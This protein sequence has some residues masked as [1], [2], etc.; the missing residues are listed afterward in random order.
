MSWPLCWRADL[1]ATEERLAWTERQL[2]ATEG[3]LAR[4]REQYALALKDAAERVEAA[5]TEQ[6]KLV[7]RIVEMT[8]QPPI[9]EKRPA[10]VAAPP[11]PEPASTIEPPATRLTFADV[12]N[13]ARKAMDSHDFKAPRARLM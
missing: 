1:V 8:G 10:V 3:I 4:E 2:A 5:K 9:Y 6:H 13:A 7:D 11:A 12:H